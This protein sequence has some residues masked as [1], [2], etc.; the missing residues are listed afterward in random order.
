MT[1]P[2]ANA[3]ER[4]PE[5]ER[6]EYKG[7]PLDPARGPGLGCFWVQLVL[8]GTLLVLTPIGVVN[9]W[10]GWLT[11]LLLAGVLVLTLFA[12]QTIIFLLRLVSADRRSRRRPLRSGAR[13]TVGDLAADST[14]ESD[15]SSLIE[16]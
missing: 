13:P 8:L 4:A 12:G 7:A 10:P 15:D 2:A 3:P 6:P 16:P 5:P 1:D 9:A 14:T 11:T